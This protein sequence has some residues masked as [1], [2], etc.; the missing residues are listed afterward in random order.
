MKKSFL[1]LAVALFLLSCGGNNNSRK[2]GSEK[3][4]DA[5]GMH[6][7]GN[8]PMAQEH[9][10]KH[11]HDLHDAMDQMM[12]GMKQDKYSGDADYDFAIMMKRHHQGAMDMAKCVID[13]GENT[14]IREYAKKMID[15]QLGDVQKFDRYIQD[16]TKAKGN[17]DFWKK[18]LDMMTAVNDMKPE[19][20]TLNETFALIM[21]P[22]HQDAIKMSQEYLKVAKDADMKAVADKIIREQTKEIADLKGWVK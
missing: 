22:H 4:D 20:K 7:E 11:I 19:G 13:N 21:I 12:I 2:A 3:N 10:Q 17:S 18:S 6:K 5:S 9:R 15:D 8:S 14:Q 16:H 1:L